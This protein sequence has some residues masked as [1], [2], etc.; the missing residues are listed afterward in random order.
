MVYMQ[1]IH[2]CCCLVCAPSEVLFYGHHYLIVEDDIANGVTV[3]LDKPSQNTHT[4]QDRNGYTLQAP[5]VSQ[6]AEAGLGLTRMCS[7]I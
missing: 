6:A 5:D 2:T 3:S 7:V 4:T 1:N